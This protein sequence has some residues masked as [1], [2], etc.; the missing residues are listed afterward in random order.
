MSTDIQTIG[1]FPDRINSVTELLIRCVVYAV[2]KQSHSSSSGD[3]RRD[4]HS[5]VSKG[6]YGVQTERER[7]KKQA[8]HVP[9]SEIRVIF[10]LSH[11]TLSRLTL[12]STQ[13]NE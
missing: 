1:Y 13:C 12:S 2:T 5:F 4:Q 8:V 7:V 11:S 10:V 6:E 9:T 3:G